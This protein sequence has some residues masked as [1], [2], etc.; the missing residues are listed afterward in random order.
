[1]VCYM[2]LTTKITQKQTNN[3]QNE[4]IGEIDIA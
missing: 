3:N 4:G 1:M 2:Y